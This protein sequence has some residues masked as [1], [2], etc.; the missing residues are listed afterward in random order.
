M[1]VGFGRELTNFRE[2]FGKLGVVSRAVSDIAFADLGECVF[3]KC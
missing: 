3:V 1:G 2:G